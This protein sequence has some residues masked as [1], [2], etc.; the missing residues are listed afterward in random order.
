MKGWL[1]Q[2]GWWR[3]LI[4]I[5]LLWSL[6]LSTLFAIMFQFPFRK[7]FHDNFFELSSPFTSSFNK[8]ESF[9]KTNLPLKAFHRWAPIAPL[10]P[11]WKWHI[12]EKGKLFHRF[13]LLYRMYLH[14]KRIG[15]GENNAGESR[16]KKKEYVISS[17][18]SFGDI[19]QN[20]FL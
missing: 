5:L 6:L 14:K 15:T 8:F 17:A 3:N 7:E 16:W 13:Y 18:A 9:P 11:I 19:C 12:T 4:F 10:L 20:I 2:P 1:S